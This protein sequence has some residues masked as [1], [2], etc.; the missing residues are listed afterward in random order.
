MKKLILF[1]LSTILIAGLMYSC[2][3]DTT[4][5]VITIIGFNP[6]NTCVDMTYADAG[7]TASDDEDGDVTDKIETTVNVDT[8]NVGTY[9]VKYVVTDEAGNR[10]E[11]TRTVEVIYCK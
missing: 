5:P 4:P 2:K 6:V 11:A 8:M 3:K 1:F 10:A 7:A 9:Y